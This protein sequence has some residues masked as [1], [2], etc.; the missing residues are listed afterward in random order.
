MRLSGTALSEVGQRPTSNSG[1][2]FGSGNPI[3]SAARSPFTSQLRPWNEQSDAHQH[4]RQ[5]DVD[6]YDVCGSKYSQ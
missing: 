3:L 4:A 5:H 2:F 6:Y 1:V